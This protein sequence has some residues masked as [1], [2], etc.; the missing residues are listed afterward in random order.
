MSR[1]AVLASMLVMGA[2][3][4]AAY[5]FGLFGWQVAAGLA[6]IIAMLVA[7]TAAASGFIARLWRG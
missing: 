6:F 3:T 2:A 7:W 1:K 5:P 4:L